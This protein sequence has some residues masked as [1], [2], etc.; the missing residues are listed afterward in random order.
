LVRASDRLSSAPILADPIDSSYQYE[1]S[2]AD[3]VYGLWEKF[4]TVK[5]YRRLTL[6]GREVGIIALAPPLHLC[7]KILCLGWR[8]QLPPVETANAALCLREM[9]LFMETVFAG[10][11]AQSAQVGQADCSL[12]YSAKNR[13]LLVL[14]NDRLNCPA[15]SI[16]PVAVCEALQLSLQ[17][18]K[19]SPDLQNPA[20][21][22]ALREITDTAIACQIL[23]QWLRLWEKKKIAR[24]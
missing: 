7:E 24:L 5:S 12:I 19:L 14:D 2:S 15:L 4:T 10:F 20:F 1:K 9:K 22:A 8:W 21:R 16:G 3:L 17:A 11:L 23:N 18:L 13:L 6:A